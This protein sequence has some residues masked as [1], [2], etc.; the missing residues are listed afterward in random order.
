MKSLF[1][2]TSAILLFCL[3]LTFP[4]FG[5]VQVTDGD[6]IILQGQKIRLDGIDAPEK[7]HLC[8]YKKE[9]WFCGK[10]ATK[11]LKTLLKN[12]KAGSVKCQG[13]T[14]DRY[15][16]LIGTCYYRDLNINEWMVESGWAM[17][18][19][20]YSKRYVPNE[21][22]AQENRFGIWR[23]EFIPPWDW[24]KGKG[25]VTLEEASGHCTIKGNIS[26]TGEKI[27][28]VPRGAYYKRTRVNKAEGELY[29]CS[30]G[31][32]IQKGWRK[33]KR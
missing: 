15:E 6:T 22:Q 5:E 30:E 32:A 17:A 31:E 10:E 25:L 28:H 24:R 14:R 23:G 4:V 12:A 2:K 3:I 7:N 19:R 27:Y 8:Q 9:P 16:R 33:S 13:S 29:F 20:H 21:T 1:S 26:S 18:Y 11:A